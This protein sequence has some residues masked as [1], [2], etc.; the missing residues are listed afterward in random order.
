[1]FRKR[2]KENWACLVIG[3][4][5]LVTLIYLLLFGEDI[6]LQIHDFLDSW[7][8]V[9]K[10]MG[11][12]GLFFLGEPVPILGGVSRN[13]LPSEFKL[14]SILYM[15][16]P[17]F[18]AVIVNWY[19][20]ILLSV[21]GFKSLAQ[22]CL[23]EYRNHKNIILLCGFLYGILPVYPPAALGFASLP[24]FTANLAGL[25][26]N[27]KPRHYV[28]LFFYPLF[29]DF[30]VFG[31]FICGYLFLFI[32]IDWIRK[33]K[34]PVGMLLAIGTLFAGYLIME[35]R[36]FY[37]MFFERE[38]NIRSTFVSTYLSLGEAI[39]EGLSAFAKGQYHSGSLHTYIVLPVCMLYLVGHNGKLLKEKRGKE[40]LQDRYNQIILLIIFNA[41]VCILY[42]LKGF[43]DFLKAVMPSL[44]GFNFSRTLWFNPFLWY[45]AFLMVL[46]RIPKK[47]IQYGLILM[48]FMVLCMKDEVYNH[49]HK[50]LS[51]AAHKVLDREYETTGLTYE[52]FYSEKLFA[53]VKEEI[54]YEGEWAVAYGMHPAILEYNEI[55][56]LDGYLNIYSADYKDKF[57]KVIAP[58]LEESDSYASYYDNWGARAYL[59]SEEVSY[60]PARFME[61]ESAMLRMDVQAF[62]ELGGEYIFSR[63]GISNKEELQLEEV[64]TF[65]EESSPYK[66]YVYRVE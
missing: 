20:K 58:A 6:I 4:F 3:L 30:S 35:W 54:G 27:P 45:L 39:K 65:R 9:Y 21:W 7:V 56:T 51:Y 10:V 52:E 61:T 41:A 40:L 26:Q 23:T 46:C 14:Y 13:Y 31:I 19:L 33:K 47:W 49:L 22:K 16:L 24:L 18:T 8:A 38:E 66:I 48:A 64:G 2:I 63:V 55:H 53:K 11:A 60:A 5:F 36:L 17:A 28:F 62:K 59:F 32:I 42:S 43:N 44:A 25:Y 57:R 34:L 50:N 12:D 15:V 29:A 1:M 37:V